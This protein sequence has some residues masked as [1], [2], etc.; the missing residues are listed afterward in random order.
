MDIAMESLSKERYFVFVPV[1]A[2]MTMVT[3][4]KSNNYT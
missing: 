2:N 3:Y 4:L 1:Q